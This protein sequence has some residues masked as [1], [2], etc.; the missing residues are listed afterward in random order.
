M[1]LPV[2]CS[3]FSCGCVQVLINC[4]NNKKL[5][6]RV[7]A[8][9]RHCNMVLE[10]VTVRTHKRQREESHAFALRWQAA[11]RHEKHIE[12]DCESCDTAL[13]WCRGGYG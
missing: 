10:N 4:R 13:A 6:G 8:F 2:P 11:A 5:L 12:E 9:D 1:R 3:L 7:K